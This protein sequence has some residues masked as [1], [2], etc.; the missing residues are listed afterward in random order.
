MWEEAALRRRRDE[1]DGKG[2]IS[3]VR[4]KEGSERRGGIREG[5]E[6]DKDP[7]KVV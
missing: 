2:E 7:G 3:K 1:R 5:W 4:Q 6:V